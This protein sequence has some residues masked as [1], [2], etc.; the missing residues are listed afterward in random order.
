MKK[1]FQ[2]EL[3]QVQHSIMMM[4]FCFDDTDCVGIMGPKAADKV[5]VK[6]LLDRKNFY[7]SPCRR[8]PARVKDMW[9]TNAQLRVLRPSCSEFSSMHA[10][11]MILDNR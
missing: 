1:I 11:T 4:Y 6:L 5:D 7:Q 3:E 10:K 8:Q 9:R 2:A